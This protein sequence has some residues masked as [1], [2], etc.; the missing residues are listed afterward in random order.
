MEHPAGAG[1]DRGNRVDFDSRLRLEF[2]GAQIS[3]DGGL[4]VMRQL[5][6]I[7]GLSAIASMTLHTGR[8]ILIH[9]EHF[10]LTL[11]H[12][13]GGGEAMISCHAMSP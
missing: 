7:L 2:K 9:L 5:D 3:S 10:M 6:D 13:I 8:A 1:S 12:L 4:V 11:S